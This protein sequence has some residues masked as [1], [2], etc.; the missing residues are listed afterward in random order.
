MRGLRRNLTGAL[1]AVLAAGGLAAPTA[2]AQSSVQAGVAVLDGTYHVGNSAGQYATTR[3]QGYGDVD[4]HAQ[5]VKNQASYGVEAR[6]SVR[7]LVVKAQGTYVAL[8][9]DD[10]DL[11]VVEFENVDHPGNPQ[12]LANLINIG[13]HPEDLMGYNLISGEYPA[14]MERMVD[15]TVGGTTIMTQ[16]AIGTSEVEQD[17]WHPIHDRELFNHAQYNQME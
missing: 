16:N 14:E 10:H 11:S 15:R 5:Q 17:R 7:A 4:S 12:P 9:S 6:E 8:V 2:Q 3:D 1:A 13:Q